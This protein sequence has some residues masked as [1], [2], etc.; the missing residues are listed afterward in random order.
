LLSPEFT[1]LRRSITLDGSESL[2]VIAGAVTLRV[3]SIARRLA[4]F[5][6]F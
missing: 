4:T 3:R 6:Q 1:A 5:V 2:P